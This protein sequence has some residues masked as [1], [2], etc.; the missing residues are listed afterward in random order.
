MSTLSLTLTDTSASQSQTNVTEINVGPKL[1]DIVWTGPAKEARYYLNHRPESFHIMKQKAEVH[2]LRL[3]E[4][5]QERARLAALNHK[6]QQT[7]VALTMLQRNKV[8]EKSALRRGSLPASNLL[9]APRRGSNSNLETIAAAKGRR[10]SSIRYHAGSTP[11]VSAS[12][13]QS[14]NN[15][16]E[17]EDFGSKSSLLSEIFSRQSTKVKHVMAQKIDISQK[18]TPIERFRRAALMVVKASNFLNIGTNNRHGINSAVTFT[19]YDFESNWRSIFGLVHITP[20]LRRFLAKEKRTPSEI[21]S[22]T[23][24]KER[25]LTFI[26]KENVDG[27]NYQQHEQL[28]KVFSKNTRGALSSDDIQQV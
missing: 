11:Y 6:K 27:E 5:A 14:H 24:P 17:E 15:S 1:P 4:E 12:E 21:V 20:T 8:P 19:K 25:N 3:Q 10:R 7:N 26:Q 9:G 16:S 2:K 22:V 18:L 28:F 23:T 13:E